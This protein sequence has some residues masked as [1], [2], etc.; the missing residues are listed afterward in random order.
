MF[1]HLTPLFAFLAVLAVPCVLGFEFKTFSEPVMEDL[2]SLHGGTQT[3][4]N[5]SVKATTIHPTLPFTIRHGIAVVQLEVH[6]DRS[7]ARSFSVDFDDCSGVARGE[8]HLQLEPHGTAHLTLPV[9]Q[10]T[11]TPYEIGR[12]NTIA[13]RETTPGC[14]P[15]SVGNFPL[16]ISYAT[17]SGYYSSEPKYR[18]LMDAALSAETFAQNIHTQNETT[19][20]SGG[21]GLAT[22]GSKRIPSTSK[23]VK[24]FDCFVLSLK[25]PAKD[26]PSDYRI[27]TTFDAV[28]ITPAL[29]AAFPDSVRQALADYATFGGFVFVTPDSSASG[30][31]T[32]NKDVARCFHGNISSAQHQLIGNYHSSNSVAQNLAFVPLATRTPIPTMLLL[33]LL[34][35]FSFLAIPAVLFIFAQRNQ[36]L[37]ALV[38][39]PVVSFCLAALVGLIALVFFGVTPTERLQSITQLDQTTRHAVT[40]GQF[41]VFSPIPLSG[42]LHFPA[43]SSFLLRNRDR[44]TKCGY[45]LADDFQLTGDWVRPLSATFVDFQR[46]SHQAEKLDIQPAGTNQ[47]RITNLLGAK[48]TAGSVTFNGRIYALGT[49]EPGAVV[50]RSSETPLHPPKP[51]DARTKIL[52]A[53]ETAFHQKTSFGRNWPELT[54]HFAKPDLP[55]PNGTYVAW[56]DGSPFFPSPFG[57]RKTYSSRQSLVIGTFAEGSK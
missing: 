54:K 9:F 33:T 6:N 34:A 15:L 42:K 32:N 30:G 2:Y 47:I 19:V 40:R 31:L 3:K 39:L 23:K 46:V 5:V 17:T 27:Y 45:V 10:T 11:E 55:L 16:S 52:G 25:R 14:S 41:G 21:H 8:R 22:K 49:I 48:V 4:L 1:K 44:K 20:I 13:F 50:T 12:L 29:Q 53:A 36:R 24:D 57:T 38:V 7:S 26:W 51:P 56:L 43:D 35:A 28:V 18:I 37:R